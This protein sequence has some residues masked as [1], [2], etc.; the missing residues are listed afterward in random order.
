MTGKFIA[1]IGYEPRIV[2]DIPRA[3]K[4][5]FTDTMLAHLHD[6]ETQGIKGDAKVR[7]MGARCL[8]EMRKCRLTV[9]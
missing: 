9:K 3:D 5:V 2:A 1:D 6:L 7:E 8:R 4:I